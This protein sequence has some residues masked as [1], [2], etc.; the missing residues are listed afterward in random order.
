MA[1]RHINIPVFVP[2]MGCTC[3]CVFCNQNVITGV[4]A[5]VGA[6]DVRRICD[7]AL[8][9]AG[10]EPCEIELAFFGGSFSG[11]PVKRQ[12]ELLRAAFEYKRRGDIKG[13]RLSTRPDLIDDGVIDRF[14][15]Y[16][17]TAVELGAQSMCDDVLEAAHRG[18]TAADV[19]RACAL[20]RPQPFELG[21]QMMV[22]LPLDTFEKTLY[23]ARELIRLRP[24]TARIYPTVVLRGTALCDMYEKGLYEPITVEEAVERCAAIVPMLEGAGIRLLRIGLMS[25]D[26]LDGDDFVAGAYHPSL[27]ELVR[28]RIMRDRVLEKLGK[29]DEKKLQILVNPHDVSVMTGN[30][31]CNIISIIEEKGLDE[32]RVIPDEGVARGDF[33]LRPT[34]R[35]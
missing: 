18:H 7:A 33:V 31:K 19:E 10:G 4:R 28:S 1:P 24:D 14:N 2:H 23:T 15:E 16:G 30:K 17:V 12:T 6:D 21:L 20:L 22:G 8:R 5:D 32:L 25:S 34:D 26:E 29:I 13:I 9:A 11:I 27:G 35:I 3:G